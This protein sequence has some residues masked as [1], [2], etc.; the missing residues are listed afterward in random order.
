MHNKR[1]AW[2]KVSFAAAMV[3]DVEGGRCQCT[4]RLSALEAA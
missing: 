2:R 1:K 4:V 3:S